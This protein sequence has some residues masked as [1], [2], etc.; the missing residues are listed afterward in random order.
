MEAWSNGGSSNGGRRRNGIAADAEPERDRDVQEHAG[1][2]K[3]VEVLAESPYS[4]EDAARR[5]LAEAKVSLRHIRSLYVRDMQAIVERGHIVAWRLDAKISFALDTE[6]RVRERQEPSSEQRGAE[7]MGPTQETRRQYRDE[8]ERDRDRDRDP[9]REREGRFGSESRDEDYRYQRG[10][11]TPFE[12]GGYSPTDYRGEASRWLQD[13]EWE[14]QRWRPGQSAQGRYGDERY[15]SSQGRRWQNEPESWQSGSRYAM[16]GG[17]RFGPYGEYG[18]QRATS[19]FGQSGYSSPGYS[20]SPGYGQSM[21]YGH[22]DY[23]RESQYGGQGSNDWGRERPDFAEQ[24]GQFSGAMAGR[25]RRVFRSPKGY[26][27]SD[28]RIR[29]DVCDQLAQHGQLDPSEIEVSVSN[30]EVTLTGTVPER[31]MKWQA[32]QIIDEVGGV[33]EIHNQLR[34]QRGEMGSMSSSMGGTQSSTTSASSSMG[35]GTRNT[36]RS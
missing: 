35:A 13:R 32:E 26:K 20:Q 18:E 12:R 8:S 9:Y 15:G 7:T 2:V 19:H 10:G 33:N 30:G 24:M 28:E 16:S 17:D 3:V 23:R 22:Q 1:I 4:W 31:Y 29:E 34:V 5:A 27:R 6:R 11:A 36:S 21:R 14:E 25:I